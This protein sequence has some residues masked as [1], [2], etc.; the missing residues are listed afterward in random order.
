M[1]LEAGTEERAMEEKLLTDLLHR[2]CSPLFSH[3]ILLG[4]DNIHSDFVLPTV[5]INLEN[6]LQTCR[7]YG[8]TFSAEGPSSQQTL[9]CVKVT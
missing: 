8:G 1:N 5:I 3:I 9:A 2:A 6:A 7:S 4:N